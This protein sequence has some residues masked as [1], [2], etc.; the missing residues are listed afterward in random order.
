MINQWNIICLFML[1]LCVA[2]H[3][4]AA[5]P[6]ELQ[7]RTSKLHEQYTIN[8][9]YTVERITEFEIKA[10]TEKEAKKLKERRFSHSTSIET[11]TVLEAY[12]LKSD[13]KKITVPDGNYQ[14]N[15]NKG[16]GKGGPIFSDRTSVTIVFPDLEVNDS[17][18]M[19]IKSVE[20]EPMFPK[21]FSESNY[22]WSEMAYDDLQVIF[23]IPE[24]MDF[25]HQVRKMK[26]QTKTEN[27]RKLITL[28]YANP[29]P[30]KVERKDF[31]VWDVEQEAGYAFSSYRSYQALAKAYG[32]R[33]LPKAKPSDRVK[34][35]AKTIIDKEEDQKVQA[36]LLYEWVATKISYAGNCI[37]VGAVVPHDTDFILDNRMGDCKDHATLLQ[38]LLSAVNIPSTQALIN[39]GAV[40]DLP[41]IPLVSAV[42]HVITYFPQW[43][44]FVDSTSAST[45]F[46]AL[47]FSISDKPVILVEDFVAGKKTPSQQVGNNR[48]EV[49]SHMKIKQDGSVEGDISIV[50][51]GD[52]AISTRRYWREMTKEKE[53]EWLK[54]TFS[55]KEKLGSATIDHDDPKPLSSKYQYSLEFNKPEFILAS[56]AGAFYISPV[57]YSPMPVYSLL[58]YAQEEFHGYDVSCGNGHSVERLT[59]EFPDNVKILA[60]PQDF[61]LQE[62]YIA[63]SASYELKGNTLSVLREV[64]DTTPGNVCSAEMINSQR[65][66]LIKIS[67]NLKSQ[68]V[69][70]HL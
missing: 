47:H 69:Y 6:V 31:S 51:K 2:T 41:T 67:D 64:N 12:T 45:P 63:Y 19:K 16:N 68:I 1:S 27:G 14:V 17:I 43:D 33:A 46:D 58:D 3:S 62:N 37:G 4:L 38:A 39:S 18:Y 48:Q 49:S 5:E 29:A 7:S 35:L 53:D 57:V 56:G 11:F 30:V 52:P 9:D 23:D 13:G 66:T 61:S 44:K 22:Y 24:G 21:H 32:N 34:K 65:Q 36:Q 15:V 50:L 59:Y 8:A 40:Y 42:N 20:T 54:N 26:Q 55:S 70:Q 60:K 10:L 25:V 28:T